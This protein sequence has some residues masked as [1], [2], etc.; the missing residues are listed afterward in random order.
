MDRRES[1]RMRASPFFSLRVLTAGV[2]RKNDRVE[3]QAVSSRARAS[4]K[5]GT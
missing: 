2:V 4:M 3:V 5:M 1:G